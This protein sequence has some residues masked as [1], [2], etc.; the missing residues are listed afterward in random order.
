[1]QITLLN[2]VI[3]FLLRPLE[4]HPQHLIDELLFSRQYNSRDKEIYSR[5]RMIANKRPVIIY[6]IV[7][8]VPTLHYTTP[9]TTTTTYKPPR[10]NITTLPIIIE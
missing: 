3:E 9:P 6:Y 5:R 2:R 1:M 4:T 8:A 10:V 7:H